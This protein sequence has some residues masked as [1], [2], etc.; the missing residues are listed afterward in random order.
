L[1]L[2]KHLALP[3]LD[4]GGLS[5]TG[6]VR[7]DNQDTILVPNGSHAPLAGSLH[8]VADGM[9]GYAHGGLA[10]SM[11]LKALVAT[12]QNSP[13]KGHQKALQR[14]LDAANLDV[15]K[16]SQR[17]GAGRM[18]TTLT[19]AYIVGDTLH[20]VHV[21]DSRAYLVRD[22]RS[23]CLTSDHT[24]VGDM[25]RSRL[26]TPDKIRTH[27]Q[28]SILTRAVGLGMFI[29]PQLARLKLKPDDRLIL[30]SDG[31]WAMIQDDE[32]ARFAI[33]AGDSTKVSQALVESAIE[34]N[35]DDNCSAITIHI[36]GLTSLAVPEER[37]GKFVWLGFNRK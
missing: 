27:A 15:Y 36:Q 26:I 25:V 12:L 23:T 24:V 6:P 14:G 29:Q 10:S 28:R 8:A 3:D 34:R 9:G 2:K 18:G 22:G 13:A 17:M 1:I 35:T 11:A 31:V 32:F 16:A 37:S 5:I 30:C 7:E 20:L 21:G 19:A 33:Q 4:V